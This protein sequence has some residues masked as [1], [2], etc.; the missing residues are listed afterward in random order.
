[1]TIINL[2]FIQDDLLVQAYI[3]ITGVLFQKLNLK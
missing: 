3:A 1:M 2:I